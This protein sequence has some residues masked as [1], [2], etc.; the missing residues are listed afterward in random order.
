VSHFELPLHSF[1]RASGA[2]LGE[3]AGWR[4]PIHYP[5]GILGEHRHTRA[6]AALFDVS[7]MGQIVLE[8]HSGEPRD[9]AMA[10]ERLVP[11]DVVTLRPGRQRYALFTTPEGGVIDDL[12]I[13]NL[14]SCFYLVVNAAGTDQDVAHLRQGLGDVCRVE[15]LTDRVLLALQGPQAAAALGEHLPEATGLRF[16]DAI[17]VELYGATGFLT[18][19]G[20][21][22]EDGFEIS[23]PADCAEPFVRRLLAN[24]AVAWAGLG[25]RDS[26]RLEAGLCLYGHELTRTTSP[27]EAALEWAIQPSRR[28]GGAR[29]G[30][31]P[32]AAAIA[33]QF[34]DGVS[35]RRVGLRPE[36]RPV[37]EGAPLFAAHADEIAVGHVTSGTFGPSAQCP[38]AMGYVPIDRA[39]PGSRLYAEVRGQRIAMQV[40]ALPFVPTHYHR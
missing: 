32:G 16:M 14:G 31:F 30:G 17:R 5:L 9:A 28:S 15:R 37:R 7:H 19:S 23:L 39:S 40:C 8:A 11:V 21:T 35:R 13:A 10:L 1:H 27:V 25:A 29:A 34:L 24:P 2:R 36:G 18:R 4:M 22:G 20:Y 12:M 6:A 26:L 33:S 38:I 3:F